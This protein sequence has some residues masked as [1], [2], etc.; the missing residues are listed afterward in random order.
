MRMRFLFSICLT[1]MCPGALDAQ[2][3][4]QHKAVTINGQSGDAAIVSVNGREYIDVQALVRITN[5][6]IGFQN[7]ATTLTLPTSDGGQTSA[8]ADRNRLSRDFMK[9]GIEEITVLREWASPL[10]TAIQNGFPVTES[11]VSEYREKA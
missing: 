4:Q 5:G 10:A 9:A 3:Q 2:V 8:S 7:G 1:L 11:W 6:S